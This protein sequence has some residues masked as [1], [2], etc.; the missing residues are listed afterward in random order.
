METG[1]TEIFR[2]DLDIPPLT[3][4]FLVIDEDETI[5]RLLVEI[6]RRRYPD[7]EA[8]ADLAAAKILLTQKHYDILLLDFSL[9]GGKGSTLLEDHGLLSPESIVLI[10]SEKMELETALQVMRRGVFDCITRP[11]SSEAFEQRLDRA[12]Q[13]WHARVRC[14]YYQLH[15]EKLVNAMTDKILS[16]SEQIEK[17]YDM[18][19]AA[20]G[21]ALDLRNPETEEHCRRVAENSFRLGAGMGLQAFPLRNLRW[22]A[23]LHDIGKIGIP[24]HIL[25]KPSS[26]TLEER[27]Q[28]KEHPMLGFRMIRN[29]EFLKDATEVVLYHHEKYD[30][31]GYP[32]GLKGEDIPVAARIFAVID[33]MDAMLYE[34]PYRK[35]QPFSEL[36]AELKRQAGR[37]FDPRVV[38]VFLSFPESAWRQVEKDRKTDSRQGF[39][40][41]GEQITGARR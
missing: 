6:V 2:L 27:N 21:A 1:S 14:R 28:V 16:A 38:A 29:I 3:P 13:E 23:Y 15:L 34:R 32:F 11:F 10:V 4:R 22:S 12:V 39:A 19:V 9:A 8:V 33:T 20:L 37:H 26:L 30:G 41:E 5:R 31:S 35:A 18:A 17:A 7:C 25:D 36:T 40:H 24:E